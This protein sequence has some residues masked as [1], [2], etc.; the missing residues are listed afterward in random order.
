MTAPSA[1]ASRAAVQQ[2]AATLLPTA[3]GTFA[4]HGFRAGDGTEHVALVLG[5]PAGT[6]AGPPL[7]RVHSECLTGDALGSWRC[8]CGDQLDAALRA[9]AAEGRGVVVYLRG[10]EGRGIGLLAKVEAYALQDAGADTVDANTALGLPVDAR[11][12]DA[13]AAVLAVLGV[14]CVRLMSSNPAKA[15]AL[16]A[17]G[18]E[19]AEVVGLV[20][21]DRPTSAAYRR[22]K[23]ERLGHLPVATAEDPSAPDP[24]DALVA[25]AHGGAPLPPAG[26]GPGTAGG[27]LLDRY[28]PLA[29]GGAPLVVAQVAQSLDGFTAARSGDARYVSGPADREHL[30]RLRALVDVVVVGVRTVAADDPL[31]TVRACPGPHPVRAVLDPMGRAPLGATLFGDPTAPVLWLV[32]ASRATAAAAAVADRAHVEVVPLRGCTSGED[33]VGAVI[34]DLAARGLHRVLVEGGATTVSRFLAAGALDRLWVT[35]APVL[36]GDGVPG[37]R[38]EGADLM[39]DALRAPSRRF[40]LGEDVAVELDLA[41][42]RAPAA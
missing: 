9:V 17:A 13:A 37:L 24:W 21:P 22:T 2:V 28:A 27:D 3:H 15:A 10:Q 14:S 30:H 4:L 36:V 6:E 33:V 23:V 41:A 26:E 12:Y 40:V 29:A 16:E 19:V 20:V 34:A 5:D 1:R 38:F 7:V 8:D 11:E 31:L 25:A 35:T 39:A 42:V 32:G 18:V